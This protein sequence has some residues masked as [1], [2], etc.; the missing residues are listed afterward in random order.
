GKIQNAQRDEGGGEPCKVVKIVV[1]ELWEVPAKGDAGDEPQDQGCDDAGQNLDDPATAGRQPLVCDKE[2]D[3]ED[4]DRDGKAEKG[5]RAFE[6]LQ[7]WRIS[8]RGAEYERP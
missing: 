4:D 6:R 7:P 1:R 3:R 8:Q 2:R 5:E